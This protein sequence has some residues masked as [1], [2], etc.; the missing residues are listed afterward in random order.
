M[1]NSLSQKV[2]AITNP[3]AIV[4]NA[5]F[6]TATIDTR[7]F[8][9]ITI[10]LILGALDVA[11]AALKLRESDADD[12]SG[13]TD[14]EGADF[15]VTPATL[16]AATDDNK[17]YAIHVNLN[18]RKRYLDLTLTGGD[19]AAGTYASAIGILSRAE[20]APSSA[21]LRGFA[22]ELIA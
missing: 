3:G 10:V 21:T 16:P 13:A 4:D 17:L 12:M 14:V 1:I 20:E 9:Y 15:S 22:Q 5:A 18:G 6:T 2:V 19:G 8:R 11:L 7:G